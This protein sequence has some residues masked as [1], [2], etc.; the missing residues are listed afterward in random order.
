MTP[1]LCREVALE[2]ASEECGPCSPVRPSV[3]LPLSLPC[4]AMFPG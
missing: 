2:G 4:F 1:V 3:Y